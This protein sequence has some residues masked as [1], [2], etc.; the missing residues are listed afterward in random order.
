MDKVVLQF[1]EPFWPTGVE[2]FS[3]ASDPSG[4]FV[5]WHNAM[6]WTDRPILVGFN[7]E[8]PADEILEWSDKPTLDAAPNVLGIIRW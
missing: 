7:T 4:Q 5:E 8:R 1:V 3:Y 2:L 6:P